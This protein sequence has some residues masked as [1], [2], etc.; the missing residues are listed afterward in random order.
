[1][2]GSN[3]TDDAE[4]AYRKNDLEGAHELG[5]ILARAEDHI[6]LKKGKW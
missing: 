5:W 6:R 4:D 3:G 2:P 1:M